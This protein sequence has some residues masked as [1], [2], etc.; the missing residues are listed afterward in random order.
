[1]EVLCDSR[2][3]LEEYKAA[4]ARFLWQWPFDW[5]FTV[6]FRQGVPQHR[7]ASVLNAV[8]HQVHRLTG[9]TLL[10]AAT[11]PHRSGDVH[12]HG[13]VCTRPKG[14]AHSPAEVWSSLFRTY[15]RSEFRQS[16]SPTAVSTYCAK[17]VCKHL[18]DYILY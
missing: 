17:Y 6:T 10:F 15:G 16:R 13:L 14:L 3:A 8:G 5:W 9:S 12:V 1:M 4:F 2:E 18:T 11:E 7:A